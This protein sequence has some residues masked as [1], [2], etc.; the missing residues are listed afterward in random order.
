M[1]I[2][3]NNSYDEMK[4]MINFFMND[5]AGDGDKMLDV[6]GISEEKRLKCNAHILLAIDNAIDKVLKDTETIV[7]PSNLIA[8]G[9]SHVF[10]GPKN[11]IW[12]LGLIAIAKLLLPSHNVESISLHKE[13]KEFLKAD[14][15]SNSETSDL[16]KELLKNGFNGFVSNRFGRLGELSAAV[17]T[18]AP[19]MDKFFDNQVDEHS[20][21]LVLAVSCFKESDWFLLCAEV[22]SHFYSTVCLPIKFLLGIDEY[23]DKV[24]PGGRSWKMSKEKLFLILESLKEESKRTGETAK[25]R[26]ISE[27]AKKIESAL[28]KQLMMMKFY[29]DDETK[30][31]PQTPQ[32]NLGCESEFGSVGNDLKKAGGAVSLQ[33]V[34]DKHVIARNHL[35]KKDRWTELSDI[36]KRK[37][38]KWARGSPQAKKVKEMEKEFRQQIVAVQ[39]LAVKAKE[40]KKAVIREKLYTNLEKCKKHGGPLTIND[41]KKLDTLNYAK[42]VLEASYLKKTTAPNIRLK[43][44]VD[45]KFIKFTEEELKQQIRDAIKPQCDVTRN[46]EQLLLGVFKEKSNG[47]SAEDAQ[48]AQEERSQAGMVGLW[49]GPLDEQSLGVAVDDSTL[50]LYKKTR[51]GFVPRGMPVDI[52]QL[53]CTEEIS[54]YNYIEK[55][56]V[57]LLVLDP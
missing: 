7:G 35:Y 34:S 3:T 2:V 30:D 33:S 9:A 44:K 20:N 10:N 38:W 37:K 21:K 51:F 15:E 40:K 45:N 57:I 1:A 43:R 56:G 36:Q 47:T 22:S 54:L 48:L 18:H 17:V 13:Y 50:Q 28:R 14:S 25:E 6:L 49:S 39:R 53:K 16:S 24:Y 23:K 29:Q 12:Y 4:S 46:I 11:S 19:L 41:I 52:N 31:I 5:R 8:E 27:T 42:T 26:L 32:T 55:G